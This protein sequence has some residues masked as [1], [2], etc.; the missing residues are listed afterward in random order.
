MGVHKDLVLPR[1]ADGNTGDPSHLVGDAHA[2]GLLVHVWTLRDENQFMARNF[3]IGNDPYAK[4]DAVAE[5]MAFFD[6]GVDG[7]FTDHAD[8][9]VQARDE[10]LASRSPRADRHSAGTMAHATR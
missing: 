1:D 2:R 10:W 4:G 3:R 5:A 7:A 9:V 8:T 6:A